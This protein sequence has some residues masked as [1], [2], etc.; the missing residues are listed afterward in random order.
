MK[1]A[2]SNHTC[3]ILPHRFR[4]LGPDST[5]LSYHLF[6]HILQFLTTFYYISTTFLTNS[7]TFWIGPPEWDPQPDFTTFYHIFTTL[8]RMY[9]IFTTSQESGIYQILTTFVPLL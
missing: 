1:Q 8:A 4:F 9:N 6:H 5:T 2:L 7:P 3:S